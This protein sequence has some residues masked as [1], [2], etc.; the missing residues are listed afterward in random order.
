M[1]LK[2]IPAFLNLLLQAQAMGLQLLLFLLLV[3][4]MFVW[5]LVPPCS[6]QRAVR[7]RASG[8]GVSSGL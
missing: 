6:P 7:E 8:Q 5:E 1:F 2:C 4:L 3:F